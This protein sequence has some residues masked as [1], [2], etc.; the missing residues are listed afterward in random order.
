[1]DNNFE[2]KIISMFSDGNKSNVYYLRKIILLNRKEVILKLLK[3]G[4]SRYMIYRVLKEEYNLPPFISK[5]YFEL[6]LQKNKD[7][8]FTETKE[9]VSSQE[10]VNKNVQLNKVSTAPVTQNSVAAYKPVK[11][12]FSVYQINQAE[13]SPRG[14]SNNGIGPNGQEVPVTVTKEKYPFIHIPKKLSILSKTDPRFPKYFPEKYKSDRYRGLIPWQNT[15]SDLLISDENEL[16]IPDVQL[17]LLETLC[18]CGNGGGIITDYEFRP[19]SIKKNY[20]MY[21]ANL[22][23]RSFS[24]ALLRGRKI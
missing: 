7:L 9:N 15:A 16:Y 24:K 20:W 6:F 1:M 2:N 13:E 5:R 11:P 3:E 17:P 22:H 8:L 23:N 14:N 12:D 4:F 18:F 10:T 19:I 21:L